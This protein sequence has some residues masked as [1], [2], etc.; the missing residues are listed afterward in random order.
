M[1]TF[2]PTQFFFTC[3]NFECIRGCA[4][5]ATEIYRIYSHYPTPIRNEPKTAKNCKT[6]EYADPFVA[7]LLNEVCVTAV[8]M[9][10]LQCTLHTETYNDV[11][12]LKIEPIIQ[13]LDEPITRSLGEYSLEPQYW[14]SN[15]SIRF[16]LIISFYQSELCRNLSLVCLLAL[17]FTSL[18]R[19]YSVVVVNG[20]NTSTTRGSTKSNRIP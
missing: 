9:H 18:P 3:V 4:V 11:T 14:A 7:I 5:S 15:R 12:V 13:I 8:C 16:T 17:W 6:S 10:A 1:P 2:F 19:M 20:D